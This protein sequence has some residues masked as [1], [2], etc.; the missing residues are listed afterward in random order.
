MDVLT[1]DRLY[2]WL[3]YEANT[4]PF[5]SELIGDVAA[6]LQQIAVH[7]P[8]RSDWNVTEVARLAAAQRNKM[9]ISDYS[10]SLLP[11]PRRGIDGGIL[12]RSSALPWTPAHT[13]SR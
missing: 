12:S 3:G 2:H 6:V 1:A 10:A 4:I 13:C 9:R 7:L 8:Q 11:Y 5:R